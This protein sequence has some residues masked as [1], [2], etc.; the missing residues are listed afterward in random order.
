MG[1]S[2]FDDK[3]SLRAIQ[4]I[5][6]EGC[7]LVLERGDVTVE[8]DVKHAFSSA[9][10]PVGGIVQGAMVVRGKLYQAMTAED[11][12]V[13]VACKVSGTWNL[14]NVA[15]QENLTLDFFSML[16]STSGVAGQ[17]GQANYVAANAF[18]DAFA[19]YRRR[20]GLRANS[21][22]L[23]PM[24]DVGYMSRNKSSLPQT[25]TSTFTTIS[26][27]LFHKII[28]YSILQ[29]VDPISEASASHMITGMALPLKE[30]STLRSDA[31]FK[32]LFGSAASSPTLAGKQVSKELQLF[33]LQ[34]ASQAETPQIL[35]SLIDLVSHQLTPILRLN[36]PIDPAAALR[37]Y[38]MES[39]AAVE[40]RNW[41][42]MEL[43]AD[44]TMLEILDAGSLTA[45]CEKILVKIRQ[46]SRS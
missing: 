21:I 42:R 22:A 41:V 10:V 36:E 46:S 12:H 39:L 28:E 43:R 19:N 11:Y 18:L 25:N 27:A 13:A 29:Q 35:T 8:A 6:A 16:S 26:E 5:E 14:H 32:P 45:L 4:N 17:S 7:R 34:L 1:R 44:V 24:W 38:G 31:R 33:N 37:S 23:G 15:Q 2:G 9:A 30:S 3:A 40:L 20:L